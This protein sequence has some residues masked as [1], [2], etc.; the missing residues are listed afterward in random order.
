IVG[1][2]RFSAIQTYQT[3]T[4]LSVSGNASIPGVGGVWVN[5][6]A[7]EPVRLKNCGDIENGHL[8]G[9]DNRLL[10]RAAFAEPAPFQFGTVSQLSDQRSCYIA[11]EDLSLDKSITIA[12]SSK[13]HIGM[14]FVN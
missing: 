3:G 11:Q 14:I 10:N 1:G 2:W 5:R 8:T 4:P 9:P 12:E 13:F 7:G 6:V